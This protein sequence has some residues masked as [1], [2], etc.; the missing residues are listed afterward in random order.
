MLATPGICLQ[1]DGVILGTLKFGA[2]VLLKVLFGVPFEAL[3][4]VRA[5]FCE[6][7]GRVLGGIQMTVRAQFA[8]LME[9]G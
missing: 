1:D 5:R 7:D 3:V 9:G 8:R 2:Q 4:T 6:I